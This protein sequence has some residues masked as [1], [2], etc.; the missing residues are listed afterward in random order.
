MSSGS[1]F[2]SRHQI[3]STAVHHGRL[4]FHGSFYL[5][6]WVG[7]GRSHAYQVTQPSDL[8]RYVWYFI[9][10][11]V[12]THGSFVLHTCP[13]LLETTVPS[14]SGEQ[15][16]SKFQPKTDTR[17]YANMVPRPKYSRPQQ[18]IT[19]TTHGDIPYSAAKSNVSHSSRYPCSRS[20][21]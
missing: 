5:C 21:S 16:S 3:A 10:H 8:L 4:Q 13:M 17:L 18:F 1:K 14:F 19:R 2:S 12:S 9:Q 6:C 7:T 11:Q 20:L 15:R